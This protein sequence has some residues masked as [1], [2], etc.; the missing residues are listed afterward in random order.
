MQLFLFSSAVLMSHF[1]R[2][3]DKFFEGQRCLKQV[4]PPCNRRSCLQVV[5]GGVKDCAIPCRSPYF[6]KEKVQFVEAWITAWSVACFSVTLLTVST[7]LI[8]KERFKY[9]ERPVIL[10]ST[11]YMFVSIG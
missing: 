1:A 2:I 10:L 3:S 7:Y 5:T 6:S 8:D 11:C 4:T 9:P